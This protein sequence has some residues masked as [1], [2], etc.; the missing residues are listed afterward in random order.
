MNTQQF[1]DAVSREQLISSAQ[2]ERHLRELNQQM[3]A[4][5]AMQGQQ[6][7]MQQAQMLAQQMQAMLQQLLY[8]TEQTVGQ[9]S[10][11]AGHDAVAAGVRAKL[12]M[13]GLQDLGVHPSL[14]SA[15]E[16]KRALADLG[17]RL[18]QI[19]A[20]G[21]TL[22]ASLAHRLVEAWRRHAQLRAD[23]GDASAERVAALQAAAQDARAKIDGAKLGA[24]IVL[25][26]AVVFCLASAVMFVSP[27]LNPSEGGASTFFGSFGV[28]MLGAFG[29]IAWSSANS[30][31]R[32]LHGE[33][34]E[35]EQAAV[36][37]SSKLAAFEQFMAAENGGRLLEAA[38]R[39]HPS[40]VG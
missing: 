23:L 3:H 7:A 13:L 27:L 40:L 34:E 31:V 18:D 4:L 33:A 15:I 11:L 29:L 32:R 5:R 16:H 6:L 36:V 24:M 22:D 28:G 38:V 8:E 1:R 20:H 25:G 12:W 30:R 19:W 2:Q 10:T 9:L 35:A 21:T 39:E 26:F 17:Q 14:F 37:M